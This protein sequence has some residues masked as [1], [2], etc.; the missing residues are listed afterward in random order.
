MPR[1]FR[2]LRALSARELSALEKYLRSP[3]VNSREDI[4]LL[5]KAY[6]KVP[7]GEAPQPEQFWDAVYP[8]EPFMLRD[9]R[10]LL[11]RTLKL[12]EG[13]LIFRQLEE[14]EAMQK[15]LLAKG[16]RRLQLTPF[17]ERAISDGH[18]LLEKRGYFDSE[19]LHLH[20]RFEDAYYDYVASHKRQEATNLQEASDRL[21]HYFIAT[22]LKQA[23][24]AHS[25]NIT[26]QERYR[27]GMLQAALEEIAAYPALLLVP[28]IAVY[29]SCYRAVVEGGE[30]ADFQKLRLVMDQYHE[31]FPNS[32]MRDIYMLAI[33]YC[34]RRANT[35]EE[36]FVPE[37]LALYR[38]SL[39]RGYLLD[40][41]V[42]PESTF[43]N[44]ISL[45]L[46]LKEYNWAEG[47]T[48]QYHARLPPVFRRPLYLFSIGKLCYAQQ[49]PTAA[50]RALAKVEAKAPFLYLGAKILQVKIFFE[51][52]ET[53]ALESL[54]ASL[55]AYLR[56]Q[57]KLGYRQAHYQLFITFSRRLMQLAP[58]DEKG[59]EVLLNDILAATGFQEKEWFLQQLR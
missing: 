30:E 40:D 33:N 14:E 1:L 20:Y 17:F 34:I 55:Q 52:G 18:T 3:A 51:A 32:E 8:G 35:G 43:S 12:V 5:L 58:Y 26:N 21:S 22:K 50:L 7:R 27:I 23:C 39:N 53:D 45:A 36:P 31:G 13:F 38:Q 6:R 10:L 37:T 56:R 41:G 54:L 46:R 28:A 49:K 15:L 16:Y 4:P 9:W 42:I 44:I 29:Y 19:S 11:S 47:F 2:I 48:E 59:R 57:K 25:R 24:L